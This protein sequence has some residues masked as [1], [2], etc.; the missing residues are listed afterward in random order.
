MNQAHTMKTKGRMRLVVVLV[1]CTLCALSARNSAAAQGLLDPQA[2]Q[3]FFD[4]VISDQLRTYHIPGAAL[5]VVKTGQLLFAK[6]YGCADLAS[7]KP[8]MADKTLFGP[9]SIAK[10]FTWTAVMQL[11]EEGKL[12]LNTDVNFYLKD[13]Q[14]PAT[15]PQPITL[16]HLMTHSA[17][18]DDPYD[19]YTH[20]VDKLVSLS[21][22]VARHMPARVRPPGELSTYSNYGAA[23]AG[24]IIEQVSGQSFEQYVEEH[25]LKPLAM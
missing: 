4:S 10:L 19:F 13:F 3:A 25:I 14:I 24:Y 16:A 1:S 23:L 9:G 15:Y 11:V 18:F 5:S 20:D 22:F 12:D 8:A 2:V 17:G 21:E 7:R 6:G